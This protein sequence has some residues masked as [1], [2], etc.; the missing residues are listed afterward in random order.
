MAVT[1]LTCLQTVTYKRC[2]MLTRR[3]DTSYFYLVATVPSPARGPSIDANID[4]RMES[5]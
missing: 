2:V 1:R 4:K 5:L 3:S